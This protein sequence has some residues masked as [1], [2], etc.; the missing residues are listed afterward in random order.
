M[1]CC[2]RMEVTWQTSPAVAHQGNATWEFQSSIK[3]HDNNLTRKAQLGASLQIPLLY[4]A[5]PSHLPGET[6]TKV[7]QNETKLTEAAPQGQGSLLNPGRTHTAAWQ[8][9]PLTP[10][11]PNQPLLPEP[12]AFLPWFTH[13]NWNNLREAAIT[14]YFTCFS[15]YC[16]LL[17]VRQKEQLV[18]D[19]VVCWFWSHFCSIVF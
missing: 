19:T 9:Q 4:R 14:K 10:A 8:L 3:A 5:S 6:T 2:F 12:R 18:A 13:Q 11:L 7:F 16:V 15:K 1:Q 17:S